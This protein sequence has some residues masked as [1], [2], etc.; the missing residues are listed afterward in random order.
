MGAETGEVFVISARDSEGDNWIKVAAT[1]AGAVE[2][3]VAF[4]D[5][6]YRDIEVEREVRRP[7]TRPA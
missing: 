3:A 5:D 4:A 7:S 2:I 1:Q 6:G